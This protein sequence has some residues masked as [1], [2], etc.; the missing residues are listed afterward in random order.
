VPRF[1]NRDAIERWAE[2]E[3]VDR[4][5]EQTT[6]D[7]GAPGLLP[8]FPVPGYQLSVCGVNLGFWL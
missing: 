4:A 7:V 3:G 5:R 2:A 6:E 8:S 1:A